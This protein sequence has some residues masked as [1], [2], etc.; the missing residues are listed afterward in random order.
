MDAV[1]DDV[2]AATS[3]PL[4]SAAATTTTPTGSCYY[5]MEIGVICAIL[6][7]PFLYETSHVFR[8][9]LKFFVYY[10]IVSFNSVVLIPAFLFRPCDVKN[11]L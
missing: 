2:A 5:Y 8:Y 1:S 9:H 7:L 6:L 4:A 10:A 11:L 3:T